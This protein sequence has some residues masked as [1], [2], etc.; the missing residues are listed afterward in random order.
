MIEQPNSGGIG[1]IAAIQTTMA[2]M[3]AA[4]TVAVCGFLCVVPF[5]VVLASNGPADVPVRRV[6]RSEMAQPRGDRLAIDHLSPLMPRYHP[7]GVDRAGQSSRS[8]RAPGMRRQQCALP[9][10]IAERDEE[11][12]RRLLWYSP[13]IRDVFAS[14]YN[15]KVM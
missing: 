10:E 8:S 9:P 11:N 12:S 15:Q 3:T 4:T 7:P 2:V 13:P 6:S 14:L 1:T 5:I